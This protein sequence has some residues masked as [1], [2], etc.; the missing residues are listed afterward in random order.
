MDPRGGNRNIY[1]IFIGLEGPFWLL[2]NEETTDAP[3]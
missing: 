3:D 1:S 2:V